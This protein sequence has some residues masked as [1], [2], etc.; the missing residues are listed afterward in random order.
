MCY[1][2]RREGHSL[3]LFSVLHNLHWI[4]VTEQ[5]LRQSPSVTESEELSIFL[6]VF[7]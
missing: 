5:K 3:A 2:S 6:H 4:H 1:A 7:I